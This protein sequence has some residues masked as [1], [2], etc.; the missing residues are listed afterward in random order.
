MME[1]MKWMANIVIYML[2]CTLVHNTIPNPYRKYAGFLTGLL[3]LLLL[4]QPLTALLKLE[5]DGSFLSY[6][7]DLEQYLEGEQE[8]S[9]SYL[10]YYDL[11]LEAGGKTYLEEQGISVKSLSVTKDSQGEIK[12]LVVYLQAGE[13]LEDAAVKSLISDFYNLEEERIYVVR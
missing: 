5:E 6:V 12:R 3:L 8:G 13:G 9:G 1:Q 2:L 10:D 11:S 7:E 4:L